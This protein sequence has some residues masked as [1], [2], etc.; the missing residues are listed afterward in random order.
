LGAEEEVCRRLKG[1]T[2]TPID[3]GYQ[4][5]RVY[6]GTDLVLYVPKRREP[7]FWED[8]TIDRILTKPFLGSAYRRLRRINSFGVFHI[9]QGIKLLVAV[10]NR[11][12][13]AGPLALIQTLESYRRAER[14]DGL[15]DPFLILKA[16]QIRTGQRRRKKL[17]WVIVRERCDRSVLMDVRELMQAG[18]RTR[19]KSLVEEMVYLDEQIWCQ[20]L[21]NRD[22]SLKNVRVRGDRVVLRD[23]GQL[24][25]EFAEAAEFLDNIAW[26]EEPDKRL[27]CPVRKNL[28]RLYR[29]DEELAR[30]YLRVGREVYSV[31]NLSR[32][33]PD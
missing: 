32:C 31:D 29:I 4:I 12:P 5:K 23:A 30:F 20:G 3:G 28:P 11:D 18:D 27:Y 22:C 10:L 14:L 2:F 1:Q 19:A 21:L 17:C 8:A 16:V 6:L 24:T 33:W 13:A 25:A 15:V 7:I 26:P 9:K